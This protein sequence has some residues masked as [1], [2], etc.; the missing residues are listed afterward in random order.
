MGLTCPPLSRRHIPSR[1][2]ILRGG[3]MSGDAKLGLFLLIV[4]LAIMVIGP[5][6]AT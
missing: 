4:M 5:V 2:K 6:L 1:G 3:G